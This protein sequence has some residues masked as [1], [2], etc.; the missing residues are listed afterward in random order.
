ME[1]R[2]AKA[3]G[4][5][6]PYTSPTTCY[7]EVDQAGHVS[8][9]ATHNTALYTRIKN[10]ESKLY[11][12]W[13][14]QYHSDLFLIDD[15]IE[16][17]KARSILPDPDRTGLQEHEHQV[18]WQI[19]SSQSNPQ[20]TYVSVNVRLDCDCRIKDIRTFAEHMRQQ[21]SWNVAVSTYP[22][23]Y[24]EGQNPPIYTVRVQRSSLR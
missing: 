22:G 24:Q 16:Y 19:E 10:G 3:A 14:G 21:K 9:V 2:S 6:F 18:W 17:A 23:S 11:A 1:T 12:V 20:G 13:P 5:D 8:Q 4:K 15:P 7:I